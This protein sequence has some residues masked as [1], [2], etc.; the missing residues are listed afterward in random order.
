M[1]VAPFSINNSIPDEEEIEWEVRCLQYNRP[2]GPSG[3]I[4]NHLRKWLREANKEEGEAEM[5]IE[6]GW[7]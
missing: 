7:I 5:V 4:S 6:A 1:T 2:R 3:M